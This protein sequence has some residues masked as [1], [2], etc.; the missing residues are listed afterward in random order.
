MKEDVKRTENTKTSPLRER[1][2]TYTPDIPSPAAA[3]ATRLLMRL[4]T[5]NC[6]AKFHYE[7]DKREMKGR[8][9]LILA[10]HASRNDP[11]YVNVGYPFVNPNAIMSKHNVLI[12]GMYKLLL[13]DGVIR[14]ELYEP[15]FSAMRHLMRLHKK[16]A[17]FLLFPEGIESTDGTTQ[18]LHPATARL[19]KKLAM[20][21]VLC[22]SHGS[23]LYG[24]KFDTSKR[25]GRLEFNFEILFR[26]EEFENMTEEEIY[27]R[28]LEKFRYND[29]EWNKEKQYKYKGKFPLAHKIDNLLYICPHCKKQFSMHV[30]EDKLVCDCGRSVAIDEC[31]NLLPDDK[32]DFPFERIDQWYRWQQ[33]VIAEEVEKSDFILKEDVTYKVLNLDDLKQGRFISVGEGRVEL[34][35]ENLRYIGTKN[36]EE[37]EYEF[38]ISR[39]PSAA[40]NSEH[41]NQI[42]YDGEYY[43]FAIEKDLR[44]STRLMMAIEALHDMTD[45]ERKKAREDAVRK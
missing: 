43:Q 44:R 25:K 35:H 24:P 31:Y 18:P 8:Q 34:D 15:D 5:L 3:K 12:P 4:L 6:P 14:K 41:A 16:G 37:V 2:E 27:S 42:Y 19:I 26:K 38:D 17:S 13:A 21:T 20:D 22:K 1:L 39:I 29:F 30:E 45:P 40:I 23:F 9:V 28:L 33:S 10:Q 11:Y 36:G 7:F 32:S